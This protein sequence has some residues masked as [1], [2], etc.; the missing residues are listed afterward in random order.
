MSV[1]AS[2]IAAEATAPALKLDLNFFALSMWLC[3]GMLYI[4][5]MALIFYRYNFFRFSPADLSPPYW[6]NMGAM[7]ISTLAGALLIVNAPHAPFLDSM[8]PFIKGFTVFYWATGTWWIPML[9][10]LAIW[11]HGVRRYPFAY[12]PL[13]RGALVPLGRYAATTR[14]MWPAGD[15]PF[16]FWLPQLMCAVGI[17]AWLVLFVGQLRALGH[18]WLA[19][20]AK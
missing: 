11:R 9:V 17:A 7:A 6:I 13:Y 19:C 14:C 8:L 18:R 15:L 3:G 12:H 1:I 10:L 4:C 16:L 2:L 20:S 5:I